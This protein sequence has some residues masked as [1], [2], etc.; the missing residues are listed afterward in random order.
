[1]IY[2]YKEFAEALQ[3]LNKTSNDDEQVG[4]NL[5]HSYPNHLKGASSLDTKTP[6]KIF[7][8]WLWLSTLSDWRFINLNK[9][10][11]KANNLMSRALQ[12]QAKI[13]HD[14]VTFVQSLG[15]VHYAPQ[16]RERCWF[17]PVNEIFYEAPFSQWGEVEFTLKELDSTLVKF[18]PDSQCV[19]VLHFKK[20]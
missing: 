7:P 5:V 14:S 4:S 3:W 18:Q 13:K 17:K 6:I 20:E 12:V 15:H 19:I 1:M 10:F 11:E 2:I 8:S 9:N 16:G